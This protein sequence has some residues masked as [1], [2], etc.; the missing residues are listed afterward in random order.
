MNVDGIGQF[1]QMMQGMQ[2]M[3]GMPP[4]PPSAE[5]IS[6]KTFDEKDTNEDGVLSAEELGISEE[7]FS[8]LDTDDDGAVSQDELVA[9]IAEI[10]Q[11]TDQDGEKPDINAIKSALAEIGITMPEKPGDGPQGPPP[12][13]AGE[14]TGYDLISQG[15][16]QLGLTEEEQ[17][18]ILETIKNQTFDTQA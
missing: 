10:L 11:I 15:L 17:S 3:R 18:S 14:Q 16:N 8:S 9:K 1:N 13:P 7:A 4:A 6:T 5:D 12:P 2:G